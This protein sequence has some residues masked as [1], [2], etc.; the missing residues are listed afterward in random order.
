VATAYR[1]KRFNF[2]LTG[3]VGAR[4]KPTV[5]LNFVMDSKLRL[6][7]GD[8]LNLNHS[9]YQKAEPNTYYVLMEVMQE[10]QYV[11]HHVQKI[12]AFFAAMRN[13]AHTL[14][15]QGHEVIY[16]RLDDAENL[17]HFDL[18]LDHIIKTKA[19]TRFEYQLPDEYRLDEQLKSFASGLSIETLVAE[20]EHFLTYRAEVADFFGGKKQYLMEN[21]YRYMRKKHVVLMNGSKPV[22]DK[23]NFD[24]FNRKKYDHKVPLENAITYDHD[25]SVLKTMIDTMGV[26]YFGEVDAGHFPWP[27]SRKEALQSIMYFCENLL[28]HFGTYEDAMLQQHISLFHSRLSFTLNCKMVAP[29]E[30]IAMVVN[31][32][33]QFK[34]EINIAQVEGFVRQILGWREFMRGVYW[35]QMPGFAI[36]NFFNH[37]KEL[38]AWYWDGNTKMNCL[39]K[40][41]GQSLQH[42]WAHHIQR[43][44]VIG[45]FSLLAGLHPTEVDAW[46]LGVYIDAIEWVEITNTRGMS[47]F[48]DGGIV[49]SKP[50]VSSAAYINKMSDYCKH[51]TYNK[52]LRVGAN[53]C[54][55]NSL[56]WNFYFSHADKLRGNHRIGVMYKLLDKMPPAEIEALNNQAEHYLSHINEL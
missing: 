9:W 32:W 56:Y 7:L 43:L 15:K 26:K 14:V 27:L 39:K 49:A 31:Y 35:A 44:M 16:I 13:F 42:A 2:W 17:Q 3:A 46:Y 20:T 19:I 8:Q 55:F 54:P 52:D 10:Q 48:A 21:F 28:P 41:I 40:C 53:A 11:M 25:V 18:N 23:W 1:Q 38:P 12:L 37:T 5:I 29:A 47:Q 4:T 45:N 50:Y 51:C 33:Q 22:A 34:D 30:V 6:I 24:E 36:T